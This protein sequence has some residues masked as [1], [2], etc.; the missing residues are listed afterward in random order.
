MNKE[1]MM[2]KKRFIDLSNMSYNR[3]IP[4]FTDFLSIN[5]LSILNTTKASE[6]STKYETFG[7]YEFAERQMAM[8]V[9]DAL[10]YEAEYPISVIKIYPKYAKF[11]QSLGHRDYLG[12]LVNL[13]VDRS[14]IGDIIVLSDEAYV[15]CAE[16]L[17]DFFCEELKQI[18]HTIVETVKCDLPEEIAK[19][20]LMEI[21]GTVS[22]LR[23]DNIV[24]FVTRQSR[25]SVLEL[26]RT[27]KVF[28]NGRLVESNS[29][30]VKEEDII[31]VRGVGK[32]IFKQVLNVTKKDRL[33]VLINKYGN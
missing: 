17:A 32:F 31:T 25:S 14:K 24:A 13:G 8:F 3:G 1:E 15:F 12:A 23:I 5:E 4:V 2:Q 30:T 20:S 9:P 28:V 16:K 10:F 11:A 21:T 27:Q 19:P 29:M 33:N 6:L 7:G 22:S 26:F 18:K